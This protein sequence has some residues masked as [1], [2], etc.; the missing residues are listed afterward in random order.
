MFSEKFKGTF[1]EVPT[2]RY[3]KYELVLVDCIEISS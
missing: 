1:F 3:N 2:L